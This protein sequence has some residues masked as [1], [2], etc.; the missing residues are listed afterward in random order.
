MMVVELY[1][2]LDTH[3]HIGIQVAKLAH[4]MRIDAGL[5][6]RRKEFLSVS[7]QGFH[8]NSLAYHTI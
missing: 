3:V 1:E 8:A 2:V 5:A 4:L 7:A 6:V